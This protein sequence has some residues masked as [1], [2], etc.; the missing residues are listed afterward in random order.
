MYLRKSLGALTP[1]Q[2][3]QVSTLKAGMQMPMW[4]VLGVGAFLWIFLGRKGSKKKVGRSGHDP[5]YGT[6]LDWTDPKN[7]AKIGRAMRKK[8]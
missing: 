4:A 7:D 3:E 2:E 6:G 1:E 5:A 8:R